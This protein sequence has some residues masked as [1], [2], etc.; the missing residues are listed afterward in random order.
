M[1]NG[2]P[3]RP[4]ERPAASLPDGVD[5]LGVPQPDRTRHTFV[6]VMAV[7]VALLAL[8][9]TLGWVVYDTLARSGT[10]DGQRAVIETSAQC[11]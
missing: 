10:L 11:S 9:F 4:G 8:I 5:P 7:V 6:V 3:D 1:T 2:V